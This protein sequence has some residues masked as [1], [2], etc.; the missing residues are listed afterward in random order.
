MENAIE[1]ARDSSSIVL[2]CTA[3]APACIVGL[4]PNF[5]GLSVACD[6]QLLSLRSKLY[7]ESL[8]LE[9]SLRGLELPLR[10][11]VG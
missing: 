3:T 1:T 6:L 8:K 9:T 10:L 7:E 5:Y 4:T 11:G 2:H